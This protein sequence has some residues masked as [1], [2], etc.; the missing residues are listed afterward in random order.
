MKIGCFALV[1]PF[2][3]LEHQFARVRE[4]GIGYVDIT[5]NH[6][7]A[8][9]GREFG[10]AATASLDGHP[11]A[12]RAMA[13]RHGLTISAV[14]AHANLLDPASPE[15]YGTAQIIKAIKLAHFLGVGEVITTEGDPRTAF[16]H[17]LS[18]AERVFSIVEKLQT[19][20]EWAKALG[21]RLLL[22][23]HGPVTDSVSLMGAVLERLGNEDVIGVCLDTGNAW[24]GGAEPLEF[25]RAFGPRIH[26]VHWKDM[27]AEMEAERGKRFGCGMGLI[28]LG[29]GVVGI[30]RIVQALAE[31]GFAGH[32]TLEVAGAEAVRVSAER[33]R[34]FATQA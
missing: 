30:E 19:P 6:D 33:L 31:V 15:R 14:C 9:L 22:E 13:R 2:T 16:G 12:L 10:F 23:P 7:G 21:V 11:E 32:T 4:L 25:V 20:V 17:G 29:D 26:H 8:S 24:L 27:P 5:D 18:E 34:K 1:D 28:P 3:P